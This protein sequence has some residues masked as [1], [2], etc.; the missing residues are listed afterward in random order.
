MHQGGT[1]AGDSLWKRVCPFAPLSVSPSQLPPESA[2]SAGLGGAGASA[3]LCQTSPNIPFIH[4]PRR[5][6]SLPPANHLPSRLSLTFTLTQPETVFSW[7]Q[8]PSLGTSW[9]CNLTTCSGTNILRTRSSLPS[10]D[11]ILQSQL[12]PPR[13][14]GFR[15]G[16]MPPL[17]P[18]LKFRKFSW[19]W[20]GGVVVKF[21]CSTLMAGVHGFRSQGQTCTPL[22]KPCCSDIPHTK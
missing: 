21:V 12:S 9:A 11:L 8:P 14:L 18:N 6:P 2:E 22:I 20:P 4:Q 7:P 13:P 5:V 10:R 16:P 15:P 1:G 19:G 3:S 17:G